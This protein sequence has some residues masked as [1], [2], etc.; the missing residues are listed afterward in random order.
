MNTS[1]EY[2]SLLTIF[3]LAQSLLG[4]SELVLRERK[5]FK[6]QTMLLVLHITKENDSIYILLHSL[7]FMRKIGKDNREIRNTLI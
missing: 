5:E 4:I 6:I 1:V 3:G 2:T 7:R